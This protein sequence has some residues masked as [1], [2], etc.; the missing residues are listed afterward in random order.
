MKSILKEMARRIKELEYEVKMLKQTLLVK[1]DNDFE[2]YKWKYDR[3]MII[4]DL[5]VTKTFLIFTK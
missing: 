3:K 4:N 5:E 2:R 1:S